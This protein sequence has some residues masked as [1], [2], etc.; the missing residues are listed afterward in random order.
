MSAPDI[1][2]HAFP[3]AY[4]APTGLAKIELRLAVLA[5]FLAPMN[6]FRL[7]DVYLTLGDLVVGLC[8]L[9]LL[10]RPQ[11]LGERLRML[12]R[13]YGLG[14][15]CLI[16]GLLLAS[17][18]N[19]DPVRGLVGQVQYLFAYGVLPL[20]FLR[21]SPEDALLIAKAF[22]A[23]I[24]VLCLHGIWLTTLEGPVDMRFLSGSGRLRGLVERENAFA[25]LIAMTVPLVIWMIR[26]AVLRFWIGLLFLGLMLYT[27]MLTGSNTGLFSFV[28]AVVLMQLASPKPLRDGLLLA[29]FG[30]VAVFLFI[31]FGEAFLPDIFV[32]RVYGALSSGDMSQAGTLMD[33]LYLNFEALQI[34]HTNLLI[35]QGMD[36]YRLNSVYEAP[37]HN[38][39]LLLLN[40]GGLITIIGLMMMFVAIATIG[41]TLV[42][43]RDTR[44]TGSYLLVTFTIFVLVISATPHVYG[45]FWILPWLVALGLALAERRATTFSFSHK[46]F[47]ID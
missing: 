6:A 26:R 30:G 16:F 1:S 40:E 8:F 23:A 41:L 46:S 27:I 43:R 7:D 24:L 11:L 34:A 33:R 20:I 19:G 13:F 12:P 17:I 37:V 47:R 22:L 28:F 15:F 25:A 9:L 10:A 35:G 4:S 21:A 42:V 39:Y 3:G 18:V 29:A 31:A 32:K 45:R 44:V 2:S 5:V 36:Q 38:A 14:L